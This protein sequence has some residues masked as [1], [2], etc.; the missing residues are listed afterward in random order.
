MD[1]RTPR[2][3][4]RALIGIAS[5]LLAVPLIAAATLATSGGQAGLAAVRNATA[6]FHD[7]EAAKDAGYAEF[8]VCTDDADEG[9][10]GQHFVNIELVLKPEIDPLQPEAL[11]YEPRRNGGYKLVGVEYVTF[12]AEWH[13]AFGKTAPTVLGTNL[14]PMPAG[15]RYG[16]PPFYQRHAWIWAPNPRGVFNDWNSRVTCR[17]QGDPA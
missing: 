2:L 11:V 15:N 9:A 8:Y 17:G 7:L 3:R 13:A 10:M 14:K 16:L 1:E 12:Q 4:A 5:A 6:A